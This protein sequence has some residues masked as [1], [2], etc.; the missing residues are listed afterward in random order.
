MIRA[1]QMIDCRIRNDKLIQCSVKTL[2]L[3]PGEHYYFT[4]S[5]DN[6]VANKNIFLSFLYQAH[7]FS[8]LMY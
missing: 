3:V 5:L 1:Y 6:Q 4:L 2:F 8:H 7:K